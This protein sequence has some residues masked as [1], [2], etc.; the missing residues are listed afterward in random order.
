MILKK[1]ISSL[2]EM[3]LMVVEEEL[4]VVDLNQGLVLEEITIQVEIQFHVKK[5]ILASE[6]VKLGM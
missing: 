1:N 5:I 2:V 3:I 4:V 6:I